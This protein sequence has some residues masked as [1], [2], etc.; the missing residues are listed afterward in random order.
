MWAI[1]FSLV[2]PECSD[3]VSVPLNGLLDLELIL[4]ELLELR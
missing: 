3:D 1:G 2:D 4:A